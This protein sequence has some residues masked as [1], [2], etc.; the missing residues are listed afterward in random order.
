MKKIGVLTF[1]ASYNFGSNLQAYALQEYV[2]KI[3]N[4][5]VEYEIINFRTDK[6]IQLYTSFLEKKG[7]APALYGTSNSSYIENEGGVDY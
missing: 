2:K 4:N 5:N 7:L 3:M 6:Q 1:H